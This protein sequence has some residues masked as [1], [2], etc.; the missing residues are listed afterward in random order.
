MSDY[1]A[2]YPFYSHNDRWFR[3]LRDIVLGPKAYQDTMMRMLAHHN[4]ELSTA[5]SRL[6]MSERQVLSL[7]AQGHVIGMHSFSHPTRMSKMDR[8][9]QTKEYRRNKEHLC[10]ILGLKRI[11]A[12]SHPCG[13]YNTDTLSILHELEVEIGFNSSMADV[14][15]RGLLEIPREDPANILIQMKT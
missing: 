11:M 8:A 7:H 10:K 15:E 9:K 6:W 13:N 3:Y 5:T 1:L 14:P 12:M 2:A 4:Y